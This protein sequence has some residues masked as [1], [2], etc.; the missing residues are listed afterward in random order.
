MYI[1]P[2]PLGIAVHSSS[3]VIHTTVGDDDS[4]EGY[5]HVDVIEARIS[6]DAER[7]FMKG[8]SV[9]HHRDKRPRLLGVP[10]PVIAPRHISPDS[11]KEDADSKQ[12]DG[13]IEQELRKSSEF[14]E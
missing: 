13:R 7:C 3:Q 14:F 1:M 10:R 5:D 8:D 4:E 9:D 11:S 12:E 6:E 2:F